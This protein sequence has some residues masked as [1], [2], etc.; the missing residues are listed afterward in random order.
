VPCIFIRILAFWYK[1]QTL[2]VKWGSCFSTSFSVTNGVRQGSVL[3]P[4]LFCIYVDAISRSLNDLKIGCKVRDQIINHLF[5]AD[6]LCLFCPSSLGLQ[7]LLNVCYICANELDI[8][9]N[10]AKC[11]IMIFKCFS[12]RNI[13][14]PSFSINGQILDECISYKYLGH[15]ITNDCCDNSD[16]SRQC[17]SIYAKGNSLIRKFY[18]CSD[19]VKV[20]LFKSYC[21]SL[22]CS[23]LW[24]RYSE[25]SL[26]KICVAYHGVL[27]KFLNYPRSTSNSLLFVFYNVLSFQELVR[28]S[29]FSF[30]SRLYN[31]ENSIVS[32]VLSSSHLPSS[33]LSRRWLS[34][35][36]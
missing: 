6:D 9:F 2:V 5:Y 18:K 24:C 30:Q 15:I 4:Y 7:V 34:L 13:A 31:C 11:K 26:R 16:I 12:L 33:Y 21:T 17:R 10:R 28:K 22:Y 19:K 29:I 35:L 27:K 25:T 36:N 1:N 32:N 20:S 14:L 3:S 8:V 23:E